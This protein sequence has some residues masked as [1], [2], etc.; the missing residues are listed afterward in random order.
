MGEWGDYS[1][2]EA[3]LQA[4]DGMD[5]TFGLGLGDA[6]LVAEEALLLDRF[7]EREGFDP[8][9]A[10]VVLQLFVGLVSVRGFGDHFLPDRR[11][12]PDAS[13]RVNSGRIGLC[14]VDHAVDADVAAARDVD[15]DAVVGLQLMECVG[16]PGAASGSDV[17]VL[18][19]VGP[20][21]LAL[22]EET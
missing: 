7:V 22:A 16:I 19:G 14:L 5:P 18:H 6:V 9:H 20:A 2:S 8:V 10:D 3:F 17:A 13:G 21:P 1:T 4:V 15:P 11:G 12:V